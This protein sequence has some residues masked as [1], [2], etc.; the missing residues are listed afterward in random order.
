MSATI[1]GGF[2][3][4][5]SGVIACDVEPPGAGASPHATIVVRPTAAGSISSVFD[6]SSPLYDGQSSQQQRHDRNHR[7]PSPCGT[8]IQESIF[9]VD[10][11]A[12]QPSRMIGVVENIVV[13]DSGVGNAP[14]VLP[15]A[16][17]GVIENI[18]VKDAGAGSAPIALP[19]ALIG[20]AERIIV[21]DDA[22]PQPGLTLVLSPATATGP[23]GSPHT[24]TATAADTSDETRGSW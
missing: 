9:V 15:S 3:D 23:L 7:G 17:I 24:V 18:I 6:V 16:L 14:M 2:C 19:S 4:F 8:T 11:V 10:A 12:P 1:P 22:R 20:I 21:T 13:T 5:A